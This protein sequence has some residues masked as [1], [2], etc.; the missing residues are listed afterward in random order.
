MRKTLLFGALL[1]ALPAAAATQPDFHPLAGGKHAATAK[2]GPVMRSP[3]AQTI[4]APLVTEVQAVPTSDGRIQIQC[5]EIPNP[6]PRPMDGRG[7]P[8]LQR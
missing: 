8:E 3:L 5:R 4:S 2:N 6:R 1:A 7:L